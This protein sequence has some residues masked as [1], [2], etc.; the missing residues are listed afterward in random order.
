MCVM[1]IMANLESIRRHVLQSYYEATFDGREQ[2]RYTDAGF[3]EFVALLRIEEPATT[4]W[5]AAFSAA[6]RHRSDLV[7]HAAELVPDPMP[8]T[9]SEWGKL[10][11]VHPYLSIIRERA[12]DLRE[13]LAG[14]EA[15]L[16]EC[17]QARLSGWA[18]LAA[19]KP[20]QL[21]E[22]RVCQ[23]S[24]T[25]P[26]R[27][28]VP[29]QKLR[30]VRCTPSCLAVVL[31][32]TSADDVVILHDEP[33]DLRLLSNHQQLRRLLV[34]APLV[35]GTRHVGRLKLRELHLNEVVWDEDASRL[36][37]ALGS[38][39]ETLVLAGEPPIA[40]SELSML[41]HLE[42]LAVRA[43]PELKGEW[44]DF[45][46]SHPRIRVAFRGAN[47]D[48]RREKFRLA[49]T[50]KDVDVLRRLH[51]R[52]AYLIYGTTGSNGSEALGRAIRAAAKKSRKKVK[53]SS[54]PGGYTI[55]TSDPVTARW[56]AESLAEAGV[57]ASLPS[58]EPA[59][60]PPSPGKARRRTAKPKTLAALRKR[61]RFA[62]WKGHVPPAVIK[63]AR[64]I[65]RDTVD[66][67]I[68]LGPSAS[69][70]RQRTALKRCVE[71]FNRLDQQYE[72][73]TTIEAED[74]MTELDEVVAHTKLAGVPNLADPWRSF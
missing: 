27:P 42:S 71:Q 63:A 29:V 10:A 59:P 3:D 22:L 31:R 28:P 40:P 46:V 11:D 39:L 74:I 54:R 16:L 13:K 41:P 20:W 62:S 48:G 53:W 21:V 65:L 30:L 23:S 43:W 57:S 56:V 60:T 67:V 44:I 7:R 15:R 18:G 25:A 26:L 24:D 38:T 14:T 37:V 49:E 8:D 58:G 32:S 2:D 45:A 19:A 69:K 50:H 47:V 12:V 51:P 5:G 68:A 6:S 1:T 61:R 66:A 70:G 36:M 55:E 72:F 17:Q 33:F 4:P 52:A 34:V 73:V 35:Y 9:R 64:A